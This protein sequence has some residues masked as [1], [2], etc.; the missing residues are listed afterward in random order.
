M[1]ARKVARQPALQ[2]AGTWLPLP[3]TGK[4]VGCG[5]AANATVDGMT[6]DQYR[7]LMSH[8]RAAIVLLVLIVLIL[9]AM[10]ATYLLAPVG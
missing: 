8:V 6:D 2:R 3:A 5:T 7:S 4:E 1:A 9:L 10:F